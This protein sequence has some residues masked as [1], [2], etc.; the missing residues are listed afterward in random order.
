MTLQHMQN[1]KA[2][3][4]ASAKE[5]WTRGADAMRQMPVSCAIAEV[6]QDKGHYEQKGAQ[7]SSNGGRIRVF[8]AR[9]V[10]NIGTLEWYGP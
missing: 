3:G 8:Y 2:E 9:K 10:L 5:Q 1:F 7:S 6:V 4:A